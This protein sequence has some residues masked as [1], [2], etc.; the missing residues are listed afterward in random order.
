MWTLEQ[1]ARDGE[2]LSAAGPLHHHCGPATYWTTVNAAEAAPGVL[3]PLACSY[4]GDASERAV[5][6]AFVELGALPKRLAAPGDIDG[7]IAQLRGNE[8][9]RPDHD[10]PRSRAT[11]SA[12][13]ATHSQIP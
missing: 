13:P 9:L 10:Q 4:W 12:A 6:L 2:G 7:R 1:F 3:S 5:R 8:D 11:D